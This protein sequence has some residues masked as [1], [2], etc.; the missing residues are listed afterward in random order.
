MELLRT[1][2]HRFD[3]LPDFP[4]KPRYVEVEDGDGGHLRMHY[5]D[6]GPEDGELILCVH[7]QP[8]WSYSFRKMIPVLVSG[9]F[10]VVAPDIVG[11]GRS[12][13]PAKR[14]D[15]TY[16][17]HVH[18]FRGFMQALSLR[19]VNLLCHDWGGPISLRVL[20][21]KPERFSRVITTNTGLPDARD[22]PEDMAPRLRKLLADT[23]AL[24]P[25]EMMRA[26]LASEKP[27]KRRGMQEQAKEAA[28]GSQ[29]RPSFMYWIRHCDGYPDFDPGEIIALWL[30][31]CSSEEK[32]AYSAPFP[33]EEFMQGA[34]Q[35]PSLIPLFPDDPAVADNR[36]A[37]EVLRAFDK[38]FLTVFSESEPQ[39]AAL[40]FQ[41]EVPGARGQ[42]H[43]LLSRARHFPQD[44]CPKELAEI[45]I[46]FIK[47][48]PR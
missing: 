22:V 1:P 37:W 15:Y 42:N 31:E 32:R 3:N 40:Q 23:P 12:D 48:N 41:R 13:K 9:G 30:N 44:D 2:E 47:S 11:F 7:G 33:A 10:R 21:E 14:S 27:E 45:V 26:A 16:A 8:T 4:F 46:E 6:E 24:A 43:Q 36:R 38:P 28:G 17:K 39:A 19:D 25:E 34:R 35:F 18:W 5:L 29:N 20:S